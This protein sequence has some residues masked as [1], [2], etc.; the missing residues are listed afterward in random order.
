MTRLV[1]LAGTTLALG[2][3]V[4]AP[5]A[6]LGQA[7]TAPAP[8]TMAATQ[9]GAYAEQRCAGC[10]AIGMNDASPRA[11]APPLRDFFKRYPRDGLRVAFMNG[12]H[13]G[14][15]DMPVFRLSAE[16]ADQLIA[17]LRSVDPCVQDSRDRAAMDR[18]FAPL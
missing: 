13:M 6:T 15:P 8:L 9:G 11:N 1:L 18:C 16:E 17:Y 3:C 10:H 14:A 5:P 7:A 4:P 2:A 12:L